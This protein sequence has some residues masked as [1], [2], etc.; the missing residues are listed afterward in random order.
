MIGL[1][2]YGHTEQLAK[3]LGIRVTDLLRDPQ[4]RLDNRLDVDYFLVHLLD[5]LEQNEQLLAVGA[6]QALERVG[7]L[8]QRLQTHDQVLE[9]VIIKV[10]PL[11][12]THQSLEKLNV[13]QKEF[14]RKC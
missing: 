4:H 5:I 2:V 3:E 7:V 14:Y 12:V 10:V 13:V 9:N 6:E 11:E 1:D 8:H